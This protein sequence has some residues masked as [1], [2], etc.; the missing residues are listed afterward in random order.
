MSVENSDGKELRNVALAIGT[1]RTRWGHY[2]KVTTFFITFVL[3]LLIPMGVIV[4]YYLWKHGAQIIS[5]REA[6]TVSSA[7]LLEYGNSMGEE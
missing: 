2:L 6:L 4:I 5:E 7:T 3:T 1:A